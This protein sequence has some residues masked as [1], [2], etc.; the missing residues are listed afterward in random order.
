VHTL[1]NDIRVEYD[2]KRLGKT[3]AEMETI[4]TPMGRRLEPDEIAPLAVYL[5]SKESASM[6]GQAIN[7]DGGILMTG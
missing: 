2:A 1:I 5:A 3:F 6:T 7:I 4:M